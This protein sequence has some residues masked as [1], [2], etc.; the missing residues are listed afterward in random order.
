MCIAGCGGGS[1]ASALEAAVL[2]HGHHVIQHCMQVGR[3]GRLHDGAMS[4]A[5]GV[6]DAAKM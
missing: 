4:A 5:R 6:A 3:E 2:E 1:G